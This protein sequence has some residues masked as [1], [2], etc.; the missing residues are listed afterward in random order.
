MV[1]KE[2]AKESE[3]SGEIEIPVKDSTSKNVYSY[4]TIKRNIPGDTVNMLMAKGL[5]YQDVHK[6]AIFINRDCTRWEL[7]GTNTYIGKRCRTNPGNKD[8]FWYFGNPRGSFYICEGAIDA[9]SLYELRGRKPGWYAS[10]PG[11]SHQAIIDRIV[12]DGRFHV[13]FT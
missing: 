8:Q 12:N 10:I 6:N 1:H 7:R 5:L 11:V 9:I 3:P 2:T 4:L 13:V